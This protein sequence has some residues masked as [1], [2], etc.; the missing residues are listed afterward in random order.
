MMIPEEFKALI[1]RAAEVLGLTKK[2]VANMTFLET[3][4][5]LVEAL[6]KAW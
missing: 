5:A 2:E 6:E 4:E 3:I 1:E